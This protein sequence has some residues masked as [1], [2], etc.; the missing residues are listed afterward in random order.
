R[1]VHGPLPTDSNSAATPSQ[2]DSKPAGEYRS[3]QFATRHPRSNY[4]DTAYRLEPAAQMPP[5]RPGTRVFFLGPHSVG[6]NRGTHDQA[7]IDYFNICS[8]EP[9]RRLRRRRG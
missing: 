4:I 3:G 6:V 5:N 2:T 1:R 8:D 7:R 9:L